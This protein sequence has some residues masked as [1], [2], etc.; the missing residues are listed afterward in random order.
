MKRDHLVTKIVTAA[1]GSRVTRWVRPESPASAG[2]K[3]PVPAP[4]ISKSD[5]LSLRIAKEDLA[6]AISEINVDRFADLDDDDERNDRYVRLKDALDSYLPETVYAIGELFHD[7]EDARALLADLVS[8]EEPDDFVQDIVRCFDALS[9]TSEDPAS[10]DYSSTF[11]AVEFYEQI[12]P[13]ENGTYPER[14][15]EQVSALVAVTDGME[16]MILD[17]DLPDDAIQYVKTKDRMNFGAFIND[18]GVASLVL[19]R[20]DD[21]HR[22][23]RLMQ[24]RGLDAE[25]IRVSLEHDVAAL[26]EGAI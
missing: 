22:I 14:R 16:R 24:E 15:K 1:N 21:A 12:V 10:E 4:S 6:K 9:A 26:A 18:A 8:R 3:I 2:S 17:G 11:Y 5:D 23:V 7:R 20:T 13:M 25:S 19:E